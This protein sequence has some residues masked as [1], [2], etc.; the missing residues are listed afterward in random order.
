[1]RLA[2]RPRRLS[3]QQEKER[4]H[5]GEQRQHGE[6]GAVVPRQVGK[7]AGDHTTDAHLAALAV[8]HDAVLA[9]FDADFGRFRGVRWEQP[10]A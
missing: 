5:P 8:E 2:T 6:P 7:A 4:P 10:G 1:M 9:S 3:R